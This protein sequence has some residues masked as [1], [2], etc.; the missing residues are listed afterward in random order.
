MDFLSEVKMRL[1]IDP[2]EEKY[3]GL[4]QSFINQVQEKVKGYC[5]IEE[6][7]PGL[8]YTIVSMTVEILRGEAFALMPDAPGVAEK[9]VSSVQRGDTSINYEKTKLDEVVFAYEKELKRYRK[10][11]AV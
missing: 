3:D 2:G 9:N 5:N 1:G 6:L 8:N 11:K 4:V 7:P 10:V